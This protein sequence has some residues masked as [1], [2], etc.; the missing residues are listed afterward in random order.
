MKLVVALVV[1]TACSHTPP[2]TETA[3]VL[4]PTASTPLV[5]PAPFY[6][7]IVMMSD[8]D[9]GEC[10]RSLVDCQAQEARASHGGEISAT[11]YPAQ[12]AACFSFEM[13]LSPGGQEAC[14]PSFRHCNSFRDYMARAE[15]QDVTLTSECEER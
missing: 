12:T 7:Y 5:L 11:C 9:T 4:A 15:A 2:P 13:R 3:A 14:A 8:G 1:L 6:C 10:R